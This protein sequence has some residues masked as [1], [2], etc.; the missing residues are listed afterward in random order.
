VS[1]QQELAISLYNQMKM[2]PG[3]LPL[4]GGLLNQPAKLMALISI[5]DKTVRDLQREEEE[6]ARREA[7]RMRKT[8]W[9]R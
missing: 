9:Q 3:A 8:R 1:P 2:C 4:P 6:K 7:E 5:V